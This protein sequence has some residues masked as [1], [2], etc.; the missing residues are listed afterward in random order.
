MKLAIL[1]TAPK[2]YSTM[3][4]RQAAEQ[5]GHQVKVLSTLRFAIGLAHADPDLYFRGK[6]LS[7]YDAIMPRIGASLTYFG[8]AVVR[9]PSAVSTTIEKSSPRL[10]PGER[11]T[12]VVLPE[13][14]GPAKRWARPSRSTPAP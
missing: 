9:Q 6:Q 10:V 11:P 12:A 1:S 3:R 5:R 2:C 13:R 14:D 4:L 8:T 7:A